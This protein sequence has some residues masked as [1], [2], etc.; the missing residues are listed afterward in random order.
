MSKPETYTGCS[1]LEEEEEEEKEEEDEEEEEEEEVTERNVRVWVFVFATR[2]MSQFV[3]TLAELS[4]IRPP[5][6]PPKTHN[7]VTVKG[8]LLRH[9]VQRSHCKL[10]SLVLYS[11]VESLNSRPCHSSVQ[12]ARLDTQHA[13]H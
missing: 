12:A 11:A 1:A 10:I 4:P 2:Y 13:C 5:P 7:A 3:S 9:R 8:S 6:L